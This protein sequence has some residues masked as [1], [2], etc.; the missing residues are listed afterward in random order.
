MRDR[1][2]FTMAAM[3]AS[4]GCPPFPRNRLHLAA[5]LEFPSKAADKSG[6]AHALSVIAPGL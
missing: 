4:G 6:P 2:G 5:Q 1:K 3:G